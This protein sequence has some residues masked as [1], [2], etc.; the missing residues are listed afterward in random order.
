MSAYAIWALVFLSAYGMWLLFLTVRSWK[1]PSG[2]PESFFLASKQVGLIPTILTFWATY[3]SAAAIIG[4]AGYYYIHGIGN[5]YFAVFSYTILAIISGTLGRRL[6]RLSRE[7]PEVRSPIQLYL[8]SYK[9]GALE[10]L[11]VIVALYCMIPYIATQI[12]G[13]ARLLEGALGLPYAP[14]AAGALAVI[15]LYSESGGVKNI[16]KTDVVQSLMTIFGC[17]GVVIAFL[18][19]NWSLDFSAFL[20]DV[21]AVHEESLLGI[22]GPNG[23]YTAPVLIGIA[24][25]LSFGGISM[26]HNAQ[27]YMMAKDEKFLKILMF[28]FP[29]MGIITTVMAGILGL[30]GAVVFPGLES[31]DQVI[32]KVTASVPA[33]IG[34]MATI[35]II[36]ATMSTADSILLSVGFI[37]SEQRYRGKKD[38]EPK[39]IL[40]IHRW[41]TLGIS[42]FA[43][44]ASIKPE[45]VTE[46]VFGAFGGMLQLTPAMILGIYHKSPSKWIGAASVIVGLIVMTAS[47]TEWYQ[48]S[49]LSSLPGYLSGFLAAAIITLINIAAPQKQS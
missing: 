44:I 5:L 21:D 19:A 13:I 7:Y 11:F 42:L 37:V 48:G 47:T 9:S 3:I 28:V 26:A 17:L 14:T 41:F 39:K 25:M 40:N 8:R 15:Y 45:L 49:I 38:V 18:W 34:A 10:V 29:F 32:G 6:W 43:F 20:A 46:L 2:N 1:N 23:L 36:A 4:G 30:G 22:P 35:G 27:R 33:I 12:T 31:G 24:I 16:I